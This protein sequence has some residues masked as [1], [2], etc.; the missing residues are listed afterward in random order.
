MAAGG[1]IDSSR[2]AR[3]VPAPVVS[4]CKTLQD[5]G[6]EA[7]TVGG[8][9]RDALLGRNPGDWDVTTSALPDEVTG[10]FSRTLPTGIDHGTVTVLLGTGDAAV[11][12]E[13]TTFRGEG[14]YVDGR[15]PTTVH[16]LSD[17][18]GDLARRDFTVNAF[19]WD[20]GGYDDIHATARYRREL[21]RRL[22]RRVIEEAKSCRD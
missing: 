18:R 5:A 20:L 9:V 12:V 6:F 7:Y 13:V 15:H 14:Q 11:S 2:I 22:G 3:I 8:A 19:A 21:V 16:F 1:K 17:V 4:V 10:L